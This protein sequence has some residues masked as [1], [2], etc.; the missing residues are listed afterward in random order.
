MKK[1]KLLQV[2]CI[3]AFS[4]AISFSQENVAYPT[5]VILPQ[6][7]WSYGNEMSSELPI[8]VGP[9]DNYVI[10][11]TAGFLETDICVNPANPNNFVATDNR[12]TGF[13]G[14]TYVYYTTD[15]GVTWNSPFPNG[16]TGNQGDPAF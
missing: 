13:V 11:P 14:N 16:V 8:S 5:R 10:S 1:L 6:A 4:S 12:I 9:F 7:L 15:G 3:I 2:F